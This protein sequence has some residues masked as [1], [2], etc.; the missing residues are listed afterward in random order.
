M[1]DG[2]WVECET[3]KLHKDKITKI[4]FADNGVGFSSKN[5]KFLSSQKTSEDKSAGQDLVKKMKKNV[6]N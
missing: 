1:V 6:N 2:K 5:L 4:R 3:A